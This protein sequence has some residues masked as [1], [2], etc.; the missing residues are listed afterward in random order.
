MIHEPKDQLCSS[1]ANSI[2]GS[3]DKTEKAEVK[4]KYWIPD[5]CK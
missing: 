5:I 2:S 4:N 3:L 1:E